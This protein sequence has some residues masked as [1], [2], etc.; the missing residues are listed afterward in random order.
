MISSIPFLTWGEGDAPFYCLG[1]M[2]GIYRM[3][4]G[5][6]PATQGIY[7]CP[8]PQF[9]L[10]SLHIFAEDGSMILYHRGDDNLDSL[11][12]VLLGLLRQGV[13][14]YFWHLFPREQVAV[15]TEH[16]EQYEQHR[17]R[18]CL[19]LHHF[20]TLN[21]LEMEI[22]HKR[23]PPKFN[24]APDAKSPYLDEATAENEEIMA[25]A[26]VHLKDSSEDEND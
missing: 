3:T 23:V 14:P 5:S 26:I 19:L 6:Q 16:Q 17:A 1:Y 8:S 20:R 2:D 12:F 10:F 11:E 25:A 18:F 24:A 9:S 7:F 22:L 4:R 21:H 15:P 13:E